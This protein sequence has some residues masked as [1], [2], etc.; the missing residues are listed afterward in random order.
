VIELKCQTPSVPYGDTFYVCQKLCLT[1]VTRDSCR[2]M[3]H[4][5]IK[6]VK[7]PLMKGIIKTNAAKG[8][9]ESAP[10]LLGMIKSAVEEANP[11]VKAALQSMPSI[12]PNSVIKEESQ[13]RDIKF[14]ILTVI[15]A[16]S[17]CLN[18]YLSLKP[19]EEPILSTGHLELP[20][21]SN[22]TR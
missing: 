14:W 3:Y 17:L 20:H 7:N 8:I 12:I 11:N 10:V 6:F 5:G 16:L 18:G 21:L 9:Q 15:L 4:G 19:K 22:V 13:N 1:W 2:L